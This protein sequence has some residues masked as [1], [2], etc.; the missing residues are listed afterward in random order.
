MEKKSIFY[1][2]PYWSSLF[3]RHCLDV[4]HIEKNV[5]ESIVGTLLDDPFKSKD[6][7]KARLD[8]KEMKLRSNLHPEERGN[9]TFLPPAKY[10]LSRQEKKKFCEWL[11][12]VKVPDGHSS[13][14]RRLVSL[15]DLRLIGLK[16]HD[17]HV[18]MQQLLPLALR[19]ICSKEV[20]F[21]IS[22]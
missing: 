3:V 7:K 15:K 5:L 9:A 14:F 21:A 11:A 18:L 16:T 20:R 2:L 1:E 17:C 8:L 22:K 4:M 19:G 12:A 10:T 6:G 13:N